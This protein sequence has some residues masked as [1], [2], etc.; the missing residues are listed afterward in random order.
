MVL[1]GPSSKT[2]NTINPIVT[3]KTFPALA[4]IGRVKLNAAY[5][6]VIA[7]EP[8]AVGDRGNRATLTPL[9]ATFTTRPPQA[10]PRALAASKMADDDINL[11]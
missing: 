8:E 7:L 9:S 2:V 3:E 4:R 5:H 6:A 11:E 10:A 1:L